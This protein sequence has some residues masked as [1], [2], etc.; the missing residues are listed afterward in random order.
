MTSKVFSS[1]VVIDSAWLNDVNNVVY[2]KAIG[3]VS[4]KEFGADPAYSAAVNTAAIQAAINGAAGRMIYFPTGTY[5]TNG[6]ITLAS[7]TI[8]FAND[9]V[10]ISS[11]LPTIALAYSGLFV[12]SGT[13]S[14][15]VF[16]G[17]K[18]SNTVAKGFAA[19]W[20]LYAISNLK[21]IGNECTGC[22]LLFA[23]DGASKAII[24]NNYIHNPVTEGV[25]DNYSRAICIS[26]TSTNFSDV[27]VANNVI[28]GSWTHGVNVQA[29]DISVQ[30]DPT[31][32]K[33]ASNVTITGNVIE[34][35]YNAT[36]ISAGGI[37]FS[38]I[39]DVS[40]T[41]NVVKNYGDVGIDF[42]ACTNV[43]A[44]GNTLR[45]NNKNLALYGNN[46]NILF[47]GNTCI[48]TVAGLT[49]VWNTYSD[50][51]PV[52]T[53]NTD[54]SYIG[55]SF[56]NNATSLAGSEYIFM[57]TAGKVVFKDNTVRNCFI[58]GTY[59]SLKEVYITNNT[60]FMDYFSGAVVRGPIWLSPIIKSTDPIYG[61]SAQIYCEI[62]NNTLRIDNAAVGLYPIRWYIQDATIGQISFNMFVKVFANTIIGNS[63]TSTLSISIEDLS[64]SGAMSAYTLG[65]NINQ[66]RVTGSLN[67]TKT[68]TRVHYTNISS[69]YSQ[70]GAPYFEA[71]STAGA[72]Q[73]WADSILTTAG[74]G[75]TWTLADG[76]YVGQTK[77]IQLGTYG[78]GTATV[79]VASHDLGINQNGTLT[80]AGQ[81]F[82]L[83][84]HGTRWS[85]IKSTGTGL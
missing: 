80:A 71:K 35:V 33:N 46:L 56:I 11:T 4:V 31:V 19:I 29:G 14:N 16:K 67:Y 65:L 43:V 20:S 60:F 40:V 82:Y 6:A 21:L 7:N 76:Q 44:S 61:T 53:R 51:Y 5:A 57:G 17:L 26:R 8:L 13:L 49:M 64:T 15:I 54:I 85:T 41:G 83:Q 23:F 28:S 48:N 78:G 79:T 27:V 75:I 68:G 10:T 47:Q 39:Q 69:N 25:M 22:S 1:G 63:P 81:Y 37:W 73:L 38:Q 62:S 50:T 84:W 9:D 66:N 32:A 70:Q 72:L 18:F 58:Q 34:A 36:Q 52:D 45:N 74:A 3:F 24:T 12:A 42:E 77:L 30:T 59:F 55:N 2:N